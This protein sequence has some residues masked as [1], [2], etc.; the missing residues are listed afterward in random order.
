VNSRPQ[1]KT[2]SNW[3]KSPVSNVDES[4]GIVWVGGRWGRGA[5][6][7]NFLTRFTNVMFL[8]VCAGEC[9]SR[10][11][12][13]AGTGRSGW[14]RCEQCR[15]AMGILFAGVVGRW[16]RGIKT[17]ISNLN[18]QTSVRVCAG[19][20]ER[21]RRKFKHQHRFNS[22]HSG[23]WAPASRHQLPY[24]QATGPGHHILA[25]LGTP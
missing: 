18:Y 1:L 19:E 21:R 16:E 9:Q 5:V 15:R 13:L 22:I 8:R 20:C 17:R 25:N 12:S 23:A 14:F 10:R 7:I 24:N 4:W 3:P 11:N 6:Q 2:C